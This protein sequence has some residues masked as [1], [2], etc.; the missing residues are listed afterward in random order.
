MKLSFSM[1]WV[2]A[3]SL[4][5]I[6]SFMNGVWKKGNMIYMLFSDDLITIYPDPTDEFSKVYGRIQLYPISK[7]GS[8]LTKGFMSKYTCKTKSEGNNDILLSPI[9]MSEFTE[10]LKAMVLYKT[11]IEFKLKKGIVDGTD[12]GYL[13]IQCSHENEANTLKDKVKVETVFEHE[14]HPKEF[15]NKQHQFSLDEMLT[16]IV[17]KNFYDNL[18]SLKTTSFSSF[19]SS[20]PDDTDEVS[21][22]F[23]LSNLEE[24]KSQLSIKLSSDIYESESIDIEALDIE[25]NNEKND[26]FLTQKKVLGKHNL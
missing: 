9:K 21:L 10:A 4:I 3:S 22:Q 23:F 11:D 26:L 16:S 15:D 12:G 20:P 7:E 19:E 13:L 5:K 8:S 17:F 18:I 25:E 2:N 24:G 1:S 14:L 6:F